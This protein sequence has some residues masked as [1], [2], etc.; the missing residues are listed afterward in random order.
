VLPELFSLARCR[1]PFR[2]EWKN[3]LKATSA[4][5][6]FERVTTVAVTPD[7]GNPQEP[8][9]FEMPKWTEMREGIAIPAIPLGGQMKDPVTGEEGGWRPGR[10]ATFK[11]WATRTMRPV[12]DFDK[13]IKCTLCWLQ[14]PDSVF[15]VTPEGLYDANLEACCG[16]GVCEAVCPVTGLRHHGERNAVHRQR[17]SMGGVAHR[18]ARLRSAPRRVESRIARS[19]PTGSVSAASTSR[20][21]PTSSPGQG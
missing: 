15:D 11:K 3:E 12:V 8:Y 10:N 17:Q 16:C 7:Q 18:Q 14:C 4:L 6:A 5:R 20:S 2:D 13:C 9:K 1:R 19:G 21:F